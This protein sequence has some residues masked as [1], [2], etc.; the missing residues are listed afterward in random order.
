MNVG[1]A[2]AVE[3][4]AAVVEKGEPHLALAG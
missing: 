2:S 3:F 4:A 1:G